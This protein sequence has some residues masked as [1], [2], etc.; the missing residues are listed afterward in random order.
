MLNRYT[1]GRS[2][3]GFLFWRSSTGNRYKKEQY[4]YT[5]QVSYEAVRAAPIRNA[6]K[7]A[8]GEDRRSL[9]RGTM[10]KHRQAA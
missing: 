3:E 2:G 5:E 4:M 6:L 7:K 9:R 1:H 8:T 10:P